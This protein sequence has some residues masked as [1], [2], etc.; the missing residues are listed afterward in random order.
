MFCFARTKLFKYFIFELDFIMQLTK[1][2]ESMV[3]LFVVVVFVFLV[4][5]YYLH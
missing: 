2:L 3:F 5:V 1:F 4:V